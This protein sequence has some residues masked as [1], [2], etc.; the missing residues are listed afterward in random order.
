MSE[1]QRDVITATYEVVTPLFCAGATPTTAELRLP[2]FKG[3]LRFWWRALA[4]SQYEGNLSDIKKHEDALFG[5]TAGRA[6]IHMRLTPGAQPDVVAMGT[7]LDKPKL[8]MGARYL[9]YG[10]MEA[11][12]RK[13][14]AK[15]PALKAGELTRGCIRAPLTFTVVIRC[16]HLDAN[17]VA[18][19]GRALRALGTFGGMGARSRRGYGSLALRALTTDRLPEWRAPDSLDLLSNEIPAIVGERRSG[20]TQDT[21]YTAFS[22]AARVIL[23][24]AVDEPV[25]LL[26]LVG[27]EMVRYRSW[28]NEGVILGG[29]IDREEIFKED[30]D[31]MKLS[32]SAR[33]VHPRRLAFG[34]PHNYGKRSPDQVGPHDPNLDRRASPLFIHVHQCAR[35]VLVISFLPARFLPLERTAI[36]VGGK[37]VKLRPEPDLYRPIDAFLDRMQTNDHSDPAKR[38]KEFFSRVK[39]VQW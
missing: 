2:S 31:L 23:A 1:P 39:E 7:V 24:E 16:R 35:P 21:P 14:T 6:R 36:S 15:R 37:R 22:S 13:A 11:F 26:D 33:R 25:K 17:Q 38:R 10:L 19:L 32:P 27:R 8:G 28:G 12:D 4:W 9:G 20:P 29:G 5:S 3:V 34:L 30:H 18:L